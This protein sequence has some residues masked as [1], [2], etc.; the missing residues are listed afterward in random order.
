MLQAFPAEE[1]DLPLKP[2]VILRGTLLPMHLLKT[3]PCAFRQHSAI[4][5]R[6]T[7]QK[8]PASSFHGSNRQTSQENFKIF[9][10]D[11]VK[12]VAATVGP[13]QEFFLIDK[14]LYQ[15]RPDL[16]YC[17]RTLFGARPPKGQELEDHYFAS[18]KPRVSAFMKELDEELWKLGV[19]AKTK[20]NEVAPAQHEVARYLQRLILPLTTTNWLWNLW[21]PSQTNMTLFACCTKSLLQESTAAVNTTTGLS[22]QIP[23]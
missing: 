10:N 7:W 6:S 21:K 2:E 23:A 5:R 18:I 12:R 13:E 19:L 22:R 20:H 8:D 14:E 11:N 4:Q 16:I 1:S 15:K 17:G 9:G 3:T